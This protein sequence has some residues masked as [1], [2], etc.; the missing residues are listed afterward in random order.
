MHIKLACIIAICIYRPAFATDPE[1]TLRTDLNGIFADSRL[2]DAQIGV[3]VYSLDRS[4]VVYE[5]D[6]T[7]LYMPASNNKLLTA[8]V[9]LECLG[10]DYTFK[11]HVLADGQV[12]DG[13]L[14][15]NL[16][17]RGLGDP[18][19][20]SR[21]EPKDPFLSF[22]EWAARLKQQGIYSISG[23]IL[24]DG[25]V[26]EQTAYGRGWAWDDLPEGY[27]AP[28]SALQFNE[29]LILIEIEPGLTAGSMASIKMAPLA[30][31]FTV[32]NKV[33]TGGAKKLAR[34]EILRSKTHD[35]AV[36]SGTIPSGA[37]TSSRSIAVQLPILYYLSAL[38]QILNEEGIAPADC[39]IREMKESLPQSPSLL[40][41]HASRPLSELIAPIMKMSLN[42]GAET[43][44]RVLG[45]EIRG[46]G[47]FAKGRE[48]VEETLERMGLAKD[49]YVFADGSGLS[50][51]NLI[52]AD[53]LVRV[54]RFMHQHRHF[55]SFYDALAIAG[56]DGTLATRMKKT[57]AQNNARAKTGT[58]AG[59]SALS[60]YIR[61][62]D[63]EMLAFSILAN[64]YSGS[65]DASEYVQD[66]ALARLAVFSRKKK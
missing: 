3:K 18:S 25:G 19:S 46:E 47:S 20:S 34:I 60:G 24:G 32:E 5:K 6:A 44:V 9:A 26:F 28:V 52:S 66:K 49:S 35:M 7:K 50:R 59:A 40:W 62:A 53:A 23:N 10:P 22:R 31:Y 36:V 42:L 48:V 13:V 16:I 4:E 43:I 2:A 14:K 27:A 33:L 38:K 15:G 39:G 41:T 8:A 65:K 63:D 58:Y 56:I 17:I 29:N 54:L 37:G 57:R 45:L 55:S 64:N 61:T 12:L 30:D 51:L 21:I 1:M 11:T